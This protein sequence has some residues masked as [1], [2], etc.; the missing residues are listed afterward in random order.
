M[1]QSQSPPVKKRIPVPPHRYL[2]CLLLPT[3]RPIPG[4]PFSLSSQNE[5]RRESTQL[6]FM[7]R[8]MREWVG[9]KWCEEEKSVQQQR[10]GD[11]G[12]M[13]ARW[14]PEC[15][16]R[17]KGGK[18]DLKSPDASILLLSLL[19]LLAPIQKFNCPL[20]SVSSQQ[21]GLG[22]S[23]KLLNRV[24]LALPWAWASILGMGSTA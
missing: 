7:L 5:K 17:L 2:H 13:G 10:L 24:T 19:T 23:W 22:L 8:G 14:G 18:N 9:S 16:L 1:G 6:L 20:H 4:H 15:T 3:P 21:T 12:V 11:R